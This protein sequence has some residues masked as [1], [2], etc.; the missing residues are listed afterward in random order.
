MTVNKFAVI[1]ALLGALLVDHVQGQPAQRSF[2]PGEL[3]VGFKSQGD[4]EQATEKLSAT[5]DTLTIHG[6]KVEKVQVQPMS[7]SAVKLRF[8]LPEDMKQRV[9][10]DPHTELPI[11]EDLAVQIKN[12]DDRIKYAHPNWILDKMSSRAKL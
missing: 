1:A 3:I 5:L 6:Q 8:S 10:T 9:E 11:L 4:R 2:E 7:G 12:S